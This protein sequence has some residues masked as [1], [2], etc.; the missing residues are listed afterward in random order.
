MLTILAFLI[1]VIIMGLAWLLISPFG[2]LIILALIIGLI[3]YKK[4]KKN[5]K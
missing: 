1:S 2:G 5:R 3:V 4:I